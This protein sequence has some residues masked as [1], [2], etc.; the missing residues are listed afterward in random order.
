MVPLWIFFG[1]NLFLERLEF[2]KHYRTVKKVHLALE[3]AT[4]LKSRFNYTPD[5][6][7]QV[8]FRS[9]TIVDLFKRQSS[10]VLFL[11]LQL[12]YLQVL[13]P[14]GARCKLFIG[15]LPKISLCLEYHSTGQLSKYLCQEMFVLI[16]NSCF[17]QKKA[18]VN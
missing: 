3:N 7:Y 9:A 1:R 11:Q 4:I 14:L 8:P 10:C 5:C 18:I 13:R 15:L 16:I 6:S 17:G 2:R 12:G